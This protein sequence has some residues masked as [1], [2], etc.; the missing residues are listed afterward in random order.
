MHSGG[1]Q[2]RQRRIKL[3]RPQARSLLAGQFQNARSALLAVEHVAHSLASLPSQPLRLPLERLGPRGHNASSS[4]GSLQAG[5]RFANPGL[6]GRNS[7]S[8]TAHN[9]HFYRKSHNQ[10]FY[11]GRLASMKPAIGCRFQFAVS[12]RSIS[13]TMSCLWSGKAAPDCTCRTWGCA[14]CRPAAHDESPGA[15]N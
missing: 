4:S 13:S 7:N 8:S 9:A 14:R 10:L 1:R 15:K 11:R 5:Q 6:P 12:G 3:G 2:A